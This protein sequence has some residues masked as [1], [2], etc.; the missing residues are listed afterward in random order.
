MIRSLYAVALFVSALL[1][2][3]IQPMIAK[4][5][6]PLLG[7]TPAVWNT[8]LVFFQATLLIGYLYAHG[9]SRSLRPQRQS[10]NTGPRFLLPRPQLWLCWTSWAYIHGSCKRPIRPGQFFGCFCYWL[11]AWA[12]L[13]SS[14]RRR[15][16]SCNIGS[17]PP[18]SPIPTIPISSMP[19]AT[20]AASW[21]CWPIRWS[22][23]LICLWKV[24]FG[25][26]ESGIRARSVSDGSG[27]RI[28]RSDAGRQK[29]KLRVHTPD[30]RQLS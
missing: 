24:R 19:L 27:N 17:P 13:F 5:I 28:R 23:S 9:I 14:C 18:V 30:V 2:F 4:M 7:G 26:G 10:C 6:L 12:F 25:H 16:R 3:L 21:L 15:R 22:S 8:C 20:A 1:L 11:C 29:S